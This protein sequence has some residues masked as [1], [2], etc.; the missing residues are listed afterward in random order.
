VLTIC[1]EKH[2]PS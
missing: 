1:D 2:C